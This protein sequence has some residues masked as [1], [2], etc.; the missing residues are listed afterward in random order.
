M[1]FGEAS[2]EFAALVRSKTSQKDINFSTPGYAL[3][4]ETILQAS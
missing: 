1:I 3:S 2:F 4:C